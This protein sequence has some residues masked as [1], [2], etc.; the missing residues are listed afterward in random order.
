MWLVALRTLRY[1][2]AAFIGTFVA[3]ALG[4]AIVMAC[5]GLMET[6]IRTSVPPQRLA[7]AAV[8]VAGN[9]S[10]RVPNTDE[11]T[12]LPERVRIGADL[13]DVID[14]VAG[15]DAAIA[16]TTFPLSLVVSG[17]GVAQV[18][19]MGHGWTSSALAPYTLLAGRGPDRFGELVLDAD[20]AARSGATV[21]D[22]VDVAIRGLTQTYRVAGIASSATP[23]SQAAVFFSDAQARHLSGH[24]DELDDIGV[25]ASAGSS[26][27]ALEKRIDDAVRG[28]PVVTLTGDDRGL[29]EFPEA[30]AD[31]ETLVALSAVFGGI[32]IMVA[33]LVVAGTLGLSIQL[34]QRELGLLRA[35]GATPRQVRR[36]ILGETMIVSVLAMALGLVPGRYLGRRLFTQI[37]D[38]GVISQALQYR[39]GWVPAAAAI[40]T[41]VMAA[42]IVAVVS[43]RRAARTPPT[44]AMIEADL[45]RRWLT[46]LRLTLAVIFFTG[47]SALAVVTMA[48]MTGPVA[49]STAA[50]TV[51]VFAIA[52]ALVGPGIVRATI[53]A[54]GWVTRTVPGP[55]GYLAGLNARARS[56]RMAGVVVPIMLATGLATA[57]LYLPT[58]EAAAAERGYARGLRADVVLTSAIGGI[59]P[60]LVRSVRELPGVASASEFVSSTGF[61]EAPRDSTQGDEGWPLEGVSAEGAAATMPLELRAGTLDALRGDTVALSVDHAH[62]LGV[63]LGDRIAIRLGDRAL[64]EPRVVALFVTEPGY[65]TIVMPADTLAAHT[66]S[67]LPSDVLVRSRSG[68][69]ADPLFTSLRQLA[70]R[71]PGIEVAD[72]SE[73][74]AAF[75]EDQAVQTWVSYLLVGA[76]VA[77]AAIS[78]INALTIAT[79]ERRRELGVLRLI[80]S[81]R[82]QVISTMAFEAAIVAVAGILLGTAISAT[83]LIPFSVA[84]S[85]TVVP[86]GPIGIYLAIVGAA[87][88]LTIASTMVPAWA[89]TRTPAVDAVARA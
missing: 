20:L 30:R 69:E 63:G 49:A 3:M 14:H 6:G 80:G 70:T 71:W 46:P 26:K 53:A 9:P 19:T 67:G 78:L 39:Q 47:G 31:S 10:Y 65:D 12:L 68:A 15:V 18:P 36:L 61:V 77:Y 58:T 66:T 34:R 21:G 1:R 13:V 72:R 33:M 51:M 40:G 45:E 82:R 28:W 84:V 55:A 73:V 48:V 37:A 8:V 81:T 42:L 64:T 57:E 43:G 24:P 29:A 25:V 22:R 59:A 4:T 27:D 11:S 89:L 76:I 32:A 38:H 44:Q 86:S 56:V 62:T 2:K 23:A 54:L 75:T 87:A 41:A 52:V 74:I 17:A 35:V 60:D 16:D 5:G 85:D 50:P 83:T 88:G 79:G 7:R